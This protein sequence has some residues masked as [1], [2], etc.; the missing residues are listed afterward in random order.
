AHAQGV[1]R[2]RRRRDLLPAFHA[3]VA[4]DAAGLA[5]RL[6]EIVDPLVPGL[7]GLEREH[8]ALERLREAAGLDVHQRALPDEPRRLQDLVAVA[9]EAL[10]VVRHVNRDAAGVDRGDLVRLLPLHADAIALVAAIDPL[11]ADLQRGRVG[12]RSARDRA[13]AGASG[14]RQRERDEKCEAGNHWRVRVVPGPQGN[15][16]TSATV[17]PDTRTRSAGASGNMA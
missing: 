4:V 10:A 5:R 1:E 7:A 11:V 17:P 2:S 9:V 16:A 8:V 12:R 6:V 15:S 3:H 13:D 14:E